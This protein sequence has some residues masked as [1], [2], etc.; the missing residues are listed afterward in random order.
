LNV[1]VDCI[2]KKEKWTRKYSF[3]EIKLL[4]NKLE[5]PIEELKNII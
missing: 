2:Y 4:F 5:I 3:N 1:T